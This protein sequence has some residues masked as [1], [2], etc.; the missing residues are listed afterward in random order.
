M[1]PLEAVSHRFNL[2]Y[3]I[4]NNLKFELIYFKILSLVSQAVI[5]T[6]ISQF[7]GF[8]EGPSAAPLWLSQCPKGCQNIFFSPFLFNFWGELEF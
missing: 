1:A 4:M 6:L 2:F 7:T 3:F 8:M 5:P